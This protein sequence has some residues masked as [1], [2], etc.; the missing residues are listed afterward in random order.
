MRSVRSNFSDVHRHNG[1]YHRSGSAP[2]LLDDE[3]ASVIVQA[4]AGD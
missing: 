2:W 4:T 3:D 1:N